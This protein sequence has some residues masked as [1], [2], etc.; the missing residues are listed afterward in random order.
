MFNSIS[1]RLVVSF[2]RRDSARR[3]L[4]YHDKSGGGGRE[5][6]CAS[7]NILEEYHGKLP[8]SSSVRLS[9]DLKSPFDV[10]GCRR[11]VDL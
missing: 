3:A 11:F 4:S 7:T 9:S 2:N 5:G 8:A 10:A 6:A 1:L